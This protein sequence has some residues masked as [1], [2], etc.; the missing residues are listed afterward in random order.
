L[1]HPGSMVKKNSGSRGQKGPGSGDPQ[2][3]LGC[4][5]EINLESLLVTMYS[6]FSCLKNL[7]FCFAGNSTG[8][9]CSESAHVSLIARRYA[10]SLEEVVG[11]ILSLFII[12]LI[13]ALF[14]F[15]RRVSAK[16]RRQHHGAAAGAN[17][18]TMNL[19]Q[20]QFERGDLTGRK[21]QGGGRNKN[22]SSSVVQ[23]LNNYEL[24]AREQHQHQELPLLLNQRPAS[25]SPSLNEDETPFT[26]PEPVRSYGLAG[27][28]LEA[29][30]PHRLP[31][32]FIQNIQ[33]PVATVA[34]SMMADRDMNLKDNY[35][36][37]RKKSSPGRDSTRPSS[38]SSLLYRAVKLRVNLPPQGMAAGGLTADEDTC[39]SELSMEDDC[40]RYHWDCSDWAHT[41]ASPALFEL[42]N[43]A[44]MDSPSWMSETPHN[45][46]SNLVAS[47]LASQ[48][49]MVAPLELLSAAAAGPV[50]PTR[51]FETLAEDDM[52]DDD[53]G[54]TTREPRRQS[55]E[56][57]DDSECESQLGAV[58]P[59]GGEE[60]TSPMHQTNKSIEELMMINGVNYADDEDDDMMEGDIP[61]SYDYHINHYLPTYHLG[62][63]PDTQDEATPML[64]RHPFTARGAVVSPL[65][66]S[67][68]GLMAKYSLFQPPQF[69]P[70]PAGAG[71]FSPSGGVGP[72][73]AAPTGL[74]GGGGGGLLNRLP[75]PAVRPA[76]SEDQLCELED[77]GDE[78]GD[79]NNGGGVVPRIAASPRVTQV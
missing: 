71:Q 43:G 49:M 7:P 77:S 69:S 9:Y 45:G 51:D 53:G 1:F 4:F 52:E 55:L 73:A 14:V 58:Y 44:I 59:D 63:D 17:G 60:V 72:R 13:V 32:D 20:N 15:C 8:V 38:S 31:Q 22:G 37:M 21:K 33:K 48:R 5:Y 66:R 25:V 6:L 19:I 42:P 35:F 57:E 27:D 50:D 41:T 70:P 76:A 3:F 34:P 40:Q 12:V 75:L 23:K 68:E 39:H 74:G 30:L 62:S 29:T 36:L 28:E 47:G 18:G 56:D 24:S 65:I 54:Q 61:N 79:N 16:R 26:Y 46:D 64:G 2:H 78:L 10:L 67:P 11:I